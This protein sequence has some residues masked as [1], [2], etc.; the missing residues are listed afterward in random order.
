[1]TAIHGIATRG[2]IKHIYGHVFPE[3]D[4]TCPW[5]GLPPPT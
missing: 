3:K 4:L 2:G 5:T 1:M